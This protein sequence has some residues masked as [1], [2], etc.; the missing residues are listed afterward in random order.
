MKIVF[1]KHEENYSVP[2]M[3]MVLLKSIHIPNP[4]KFSPSLMK[5][6]IT[7]S[8]R[9]MLGKERELV[10]GQESCAGLV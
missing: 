2:V 5:T 8:N 9:E 7:T 4:T 3:Y 6:M 1:S 10:C